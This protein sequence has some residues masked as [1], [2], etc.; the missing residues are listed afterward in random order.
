MKTKTFILLLTTFSLNSYAFDLEDYATT[1]RA[2]SD[3]YLKASNELALAKGPMDA[4]EAMAQSLVP[5]CYRI[6]PGWKFENLAGL[7]SGSCSKDGQ[8]P[9]PTGGEKISSTYKFGDRLSSLINILPMTTGIPT[10]IDSYGSTVTILSDLVTN[11]RTARDDANKTFT[12]AHPVV[13]EQIPDCVPTDPYLATVI[14]S[15]PTFLDDT[16]TTHRAVY[17][18]FVKST[19]ELNLATAPY[20]AAFAAYEAATTVYVTAAECENTIARQNLEYYDPYDG[21]GL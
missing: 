20:K 5:A 7:M 21:D 19:N 10:V 2:T 14:A 12:E 18:A 6:T 17:D 13:L 9:H 3:A 15:N 11:Y 8:K 16:F 4:V 1:Y